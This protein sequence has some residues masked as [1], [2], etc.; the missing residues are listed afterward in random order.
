[1][2]ETDI[3][4]GQTIYGNRWE[5]IETPRKLNASELSHLNLNKP[6]L[7]KMGK[8]DLCARFYIKNSN[9]AYFVWE[10]DTESA[11]T[12]GESF[13]VTKCYICRYKKEPDPN[14]IIKVL[15]PEEAIIR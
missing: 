11:I 2:L 6:A 8:Y 15:V 12:E 1:M 9:I 4:Q 7:V 5:R 13:D 14:I 10:V 3:F